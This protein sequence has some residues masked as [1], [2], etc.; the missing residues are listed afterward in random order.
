[1]PD[2]KYIL[3]ANV[4]I[5]AANRYYAF[6]LVPAFWESLINHSNSGQVRSIDHVKNECSRLNNEL[7]G[8]VEE[9]FNHAFEST[10]EPEIV[11]KY[12]EIMNWVDDQP[13]FTDAAKA[14]FAMGADGWLIAF[15]IVNDYVLVTHEVY[16]KDGKNRV[17]IPNVCRAFNDK[18]CINTFVM[19]RELGVQFK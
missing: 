7:T 3:D 2:D 18:T 4:F 12:A 8:W 6:D 19:L 11:Q 13:Q 14:D 17:K 9:Q 15:A 1:M 5:E 10:D 16:S